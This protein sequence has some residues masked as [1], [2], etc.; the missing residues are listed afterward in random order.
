MGKNPQY[1]NYM[2]TVNNTKQPNNINLVTRYLNTN[3]LM[4]PGLIY[5][6]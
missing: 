1:E 5:N 3:K 6:W 2:G 4:L